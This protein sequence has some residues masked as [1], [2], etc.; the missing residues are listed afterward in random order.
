MPVTFFPVRGGITR[1]IPT[2]AQAPVLASVLGKAAQ[3]ND[4]DDPAIPIVWPSPNGK[5]KGESL[6]P[7]YKTAPRAALADPKLYELLA[8]VDG[9]RVGLSREQHACTEA[10]YERI[11]GVSDMSALTSS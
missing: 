2:G 5:V 4:K 10:L 3:S 1:G 8:L 6:L 7:L 11:A 9:V